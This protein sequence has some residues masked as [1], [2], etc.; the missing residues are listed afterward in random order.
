MYIHQQHIHILTGQLTN[1][2]IS[3]P[4]QHAMH[5]IHTSFLLWK[6][7]KTETKIVYRNSASVISTD[8]RVLLH[9]H[10]HPKKIRFAA[11]VVYGHSGRCNALLNIPWFDLYCTTIHQFDL[12]CTTIHG[13]DLYCTMIHQFD[14]YCTTIHRF[15]LYYIVIVN[16][17]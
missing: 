14:L 4:I 1:L 9:Q 15:D 5:P 3:H 12:Y 7:D 6:V 8:L 13:F 16:Y 2:T 17:K 11:L 10:F